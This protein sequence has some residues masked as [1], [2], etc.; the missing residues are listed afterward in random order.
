[1]NEDFYPKE[2]RNAM[3][4]D[5]SFSASDIIH[6]GFQASKGFKGTVWVAIGI[7][8]A[9]SIVVGIISGQLGVNQLVELLTDTIGAMIIQPMN[10]GLMMLG[11]IY[12]S[13]QAVKPQQV[14]DYY[15]RAL[16]IVLLQLLIVLGFLLGLVLLV[17]PGIYLL[18]GWSLAKALL[19]KYD[20]GIREAM[21]ISLKT[22]SRQWFRFFGLYIFM[23]FILILSAI[24]LAI[25]LIWTIPMA[26]CAYGRLFNTIFR[27]ATT[28]LL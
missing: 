10:A 15:E 12:T 18:V 17:L 6:E 24:P 3:N 2:I 4:G 9:I 7:I 21:R 13:G 19:L 20:F 1:M 22:V 25:G 5:H 11:V 27:E 26:I 14:L 16:K 8:A 28:G 23:T